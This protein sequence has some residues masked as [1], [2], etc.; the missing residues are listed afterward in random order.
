M[1]ET[2]TEITN[3]TNFHVTF[4][5]NVCGQPPEAENAVV[6]LPPADSYDWGTVA[7]YTCVPG[8]QQTGGDR[9]RPCADEQW[10]GEL[11][12]CERK[13]HIE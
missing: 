10:T 9:Q 2:Y 11:I 13:L 3:I 6:D 7:E 4:S 1:T 8:Y 5:A 12:Q